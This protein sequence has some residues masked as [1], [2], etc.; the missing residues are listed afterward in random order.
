MFAYLYGIQEFSEMFFLIDT[1]RKEDIFL[2]IGAN[3]GTYSILSAGFLDAQVIAF[4]PDQTTFVKFQ[5]NLRINDLEEKVTVMKKI[6]GDK[7][8]IGFFTTGKKSQNHVVKDG[9][10]EEDLIEVEQATLDSLE[11]NNASALKIDVEGFELNVLQG[12]IKTLQSP[13]VY[14]VIIEMNLN[15][16]DSHDCE[17]FTFMESLGF[18]GANYDPLFGKINF[19]T[20]DS[21]TEG[22]VIFVKTGSARLTRIRLKPIRI[23]KHLFLRS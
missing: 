15:L 2:D 4:E 7:N 23:F 14:C 11:I 22:N 13:S 18:T 5:D 9:V 16:M 19:T 20:Y 3:L 6:L 17:I 12:A 21:N 10:Y 8:G 1:L